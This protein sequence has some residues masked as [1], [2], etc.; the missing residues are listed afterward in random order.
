VPR[1]VG[2]KVAQV[3]RIRLA[4]RRGLGVLGEGSFLVDRLG[5][6]GRE[7][8]LGRVSK[9]ALLPSNLCTIIGRYRTQLRREEQGGGAT[10]GAVVS[11]GACSGPRVPFGGTPGTLTLTHDR[12]RH[13]TS[14]ATLAQSWLNNRSP[15]RVFFEH[16]GAIIDQ[17]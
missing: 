5:Q 2:G 9:H 6:F 1:A 17:P 10:L 7:G 12:E 4:G 16:P 3:G 14:P 15:N 13:S 11:V 8:G